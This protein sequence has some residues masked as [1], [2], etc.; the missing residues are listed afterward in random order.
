EGINNAGQVV[1]SSGMAGAMATHAFL[2][3]DGA[4]TDLNDLIPP[5]AGWVLS[6]ASGINDAGQIVGY[7][8]HNGFCN[9]AFLLTPDDGS[10]SPARTERA[11]RVDSA[12]AQVEVS[13]PLTAGG[14]HE[15]SLFATDRPTPPVPAAPAV[16][17][18]GAVVGMTTLDSEPVVSSVATSVRPTEL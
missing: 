12:F 18:G 1:G 3:R 10:A 16:E 7:G 5:D 2:Y 4:L 14:I 8:S 11:A 6:D 13:N 17:N 15:D 9:H